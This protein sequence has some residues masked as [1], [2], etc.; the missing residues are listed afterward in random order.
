VVKQ[1][2]RTPRMLETGCPLPLS[3]S[4]QSKLEH[5][6]QL[7]EAVL[8]HLDIAHDRF[9][10]DETFGGPSLPFHLTSLAAQKAGDRDKLIEHIYAVLAAWGMHRMG[11]GPKM[12]DFEDFRRS[13]LA[14]YGQIEHLRDR[15]PGDLSCQDWN[16]LGEVFRDLRV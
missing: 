3:R 10:A 14:V 16:L 4:L 2:Q 8:V 12:L 6:S 7:A 11:G 9:V 1:V 5:L 13:F 15:N